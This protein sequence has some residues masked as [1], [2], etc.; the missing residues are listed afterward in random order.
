ME[1]R[2]AAGGTRG[3]RAALVAAILFGG[4]YLATPSASH[5][6]SHDGM[7]LLIDIESDPPPV[8]PHHLGFLPLVRTWDALAHVVAPEIPTAAAVSALCALFGGVTAALLV[9]VLVRRFDIPPRWAVLSA[10]LPALSAV[11][12]TFAVTVDVYVFAMPALLGAALLLLRQRPSYRAWA[13][14]GALHGVAIVFHVVHVL[15]AVPV[16]VGLVTVGPE[17][18]VATHARALAAYAAGVVPMV[19]A[20]Y[21]L[22]LALGVR[23]ETA[24]EAARWAVEPA[25]RGEYFQP[26]GWRTLP[27]VAIG[28][29]RALVGGGWV[30]A[31]PGVDAWIERVAPDHYLAD[32]RYLTRSLGT[33]GAVALLAATLAG[34]GLALGTLA[35][36]LRERPWRGRGRALAVLA[37]WL[38]VYATLFSLWVPVN[39]EFWQT[40]TLVL[41]LLV[42]LLLW[43]PG[44]GRAR[45]GGGVRAALAVLAVVL[46]TVVYVGTIRPVGDPD[47]DLL[48]ASLGPVA[49]RARPGDL[50][51]TGRAWMMD[52]YVM[53]LTPASQLNLVQVPLDGERAEDW[54]HESIECW[55]G[56][57]ATVFWTWEAVEP[58]P[59][60][61]RSL[62][63]KD[64]D[65]ERLWRDYR[66]EWTVLEEGP[67][68]VYVLEPPVPPSGVRDASGNLSLP[69]LS[70]SPEAR[71]CPSTDPSF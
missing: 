35:V 71:P 32:E 50:V 5:S 29:G 24:G 69:S 25:L 10:A 34:A 3:A 31:L 37:S 14:V 39:H 65:L 49:D 9:A 51:V 47:N 17:R 52:W 6:I 54:V 38:A 11:T 30:L 21:G 36:R 19:L 13:A 1:R 48:R 68:T 18:R 57:G 45:V 43:G 15:F 27:A 26:P 2:G 41:W 7:G 12:W 60:T 42:L 58:E 16:L 40:Q 4:I 67:R 55:R 23:P 8:N 44:E 70:K 66:H 53:Q 61:D 59:P 63:R 20:A 56:D 33:G 22:A 62:R 64:L 46:A 28:W